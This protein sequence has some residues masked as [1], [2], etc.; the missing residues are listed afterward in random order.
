[1]TRIQRTAFPLAVLLALAIPAGAS[2]STVALNIGDDE[3][4]STITY[5]AAAGENNKL[6]VKVTGNTAEISD[7]GANIT[8]GANCAA[9]N[10]KKVTCTTTRP[11]IDALVATLGDGN[12]DYKGAGVFSR[13]EGGSGNDDL[14]GGELSDVFDGGGGTDTL[15]GNAGR[16]SLK[17][18]DTSGAANKDTLNGGDGDDT[19]VFEQRTATVT[20]DLADNDGDGEAGENDTLIA[21]ESAGGGAGNDVIRGTAGNNGLSGG[22]GNDEIDGRAGDDLLIGEEGNDTLIGAAG[23]DDIEA[24][25]DNDILRLDNPVGP[26]DRI[27]SCGSGKDT[28]V[29]VTVAPSLPV[30]CEVGDWGFGYLA[31]PTPS[32]VGST[33]ITL[34]IPC[35]AAFK[36]DGVCKGSIVAEPKSAY[37]RTDA[38]RKKSRYGVKKFSITKK[39]S[40]SIALNSAGRK[41]LRKSAFKMQFRVNLKETATGTK[42]SFEWTTYT[43]KAFLK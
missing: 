33:T 2:A 37:L 7:N 26:Y 41:Q 36:K 1:M 32:K 39:T 23:R 17:D 9:Q 12:D 6:D 15:R 27:V 22:P 21:I 38:E 20:V 18:G 42:R 11:K 3:D 16:D 14:S 24:G 5:T 34:R 40:V 29:G 25:D 35:P 30:T 28:V 31:S 10:A 13:V 19:V 43:V 8:P 4:G